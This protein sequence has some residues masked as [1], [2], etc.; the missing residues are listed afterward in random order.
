MS[1]KNTKVKMYQKDDDVL[2]LE[3][4]II[5]L[6]RRDSRINAIYDGIKTRV[7]T[8]IGAGFALLTYLY[9]SNTTNNSLFFPQELYGQV[10]YTIGII[11]YVTGISFLFFAAKPAQWILPADKNTLSQ[12]SFSNYKEYLLYISNEYKEAITFNTHQCEKKQQILNVSWILLI[13]GAIILLITKLF[14]S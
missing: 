6:R 9:S 4:S 13:Q 12:P 7:L 1:E 8:F 5:E 2:V 10:L 11:L 3:N 14:S